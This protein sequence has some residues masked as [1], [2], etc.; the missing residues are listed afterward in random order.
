MAWSQ[1]S[2]QYFS[3]LG[4]GDPDSHM[5]ESN[6]ISTIEQSDVHRPAAV[7]DV[8]LQKGLRIVSELLVE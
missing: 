1:G 4:E 7:D 3:D 5:M 8:I 6:A 2:I